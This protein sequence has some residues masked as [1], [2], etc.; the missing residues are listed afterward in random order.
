MQQGYWHRQDR[1]KKTICYT[2]TQTHTH[3]HS[4]L[5]AVSDGVEVDIVLLVGK[6]QQ[7]KPGVKGVDG[8]DKEDPY[9]VPLFVRRAVIA[10]VH[11]DLWEEAQSDSSAKKTKNPFTHFPLPYT[12]N[13][14][15]LQC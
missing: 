15:S 12:Q 5:I 8:D 4:T 6:E 10:Q 3:T 14:L 1:T 13:V 11:V 7:T 2:I 9:D